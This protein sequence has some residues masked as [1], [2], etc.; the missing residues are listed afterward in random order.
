[1]EALDLTVADWGYT[2][3]VLI[4]VIATILAGEWILF[5]ALKRK[6]EQGIKDEQVTNTQDQEEAQ[7]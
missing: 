1:P 4:G 6:K 7:A 5:G 2:G 3:P